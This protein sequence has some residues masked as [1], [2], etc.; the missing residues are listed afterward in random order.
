MKTLI[1][2]TLKGTVSG[3]NATFNVIAIK[4]ILG[5]SVAILEC[6]EYG[7]PLI[8]VDVENINNPVRA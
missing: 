8:R 7:T 3:L 4:N 6:V 1:G 2:K 5:E